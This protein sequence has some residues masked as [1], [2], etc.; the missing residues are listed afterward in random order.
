MTPAS[1]SPV[2]GRLLVLAAA[3]LWSL[4]GV[5]VKLLTQPNALGLASPP[6][7]GLL[8]AFYRALFAGLTFGLLLR[9]RDV[10]FRPLMLVMMVCFAAMNVSF[11]TALDR[12]TAANA[13]IL[14]YTAPIWMVLV[15]VC[16]LK[17]PATPRGITALVVAMV[18]VAVIVADALRQPAAE[19][20]VVVGIALGSG[21][22]Y[23]GVI[24]CLRVLRG[25]SAR[26]LTVQNHLFAALVLLPAV[27]WMTQPTL[28]QLAL[29]A[30]FGSVQMALPYWLVS[31]GLHSITPQEAGILSLLEPILNPVWTYLVVGEVPQPATFLGGALI[32]SALVWRYLPVG[33]RAFT[34]K[35][36][37]LPDGVPPR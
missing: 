17:E 16:W 36:P 27:I 30:L 6:V 15:S 37:A 23:A 26:W 12:G 33:G 7:P 32:L 28:P 34:A 9:R 25:A 1:P 20:L 22:T 24:L 3:V 31:R 21:L 8:I 2:R 4:S 11:I 29:L 14:Q 19:D 10:S 18:G 5:L 13:I 35:R